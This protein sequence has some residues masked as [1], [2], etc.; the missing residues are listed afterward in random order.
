MNWD[1][2]G[3]MIGTGLMDR[4]GLDVLFEL[5]DLKSNGMD[6]VHDWVRTDRIDE[7]DLGVDQ[8]EG[9]LTVGC[10]LG[11]RYGL[12]K[13]TNQVYFIIIE[14]VKLIYYLNIIQRFLIKKFIKFTSF[15]IDL[16]F[17]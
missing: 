13:G 10:G 9:V 4:C 14:Q 3:P 17:E 11:N 12:G 1:R 16:A 8:W 15:L 6:D 5:K 2:R 7:C